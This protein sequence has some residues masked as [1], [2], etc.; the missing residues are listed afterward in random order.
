MIDSG[1]VSCL[2]EELNNALA[3]GFVEKVQQPAKDVILMTVRARGHNQKLLL[4]ASP[5]KARAHLTQMT[6]ESPAEAPMFCMLMRKYFS[7]AQMTAVSQPNDD[8][9]LEFSFQRTDELGREVSLRIVTEMIPGKTNIVLVG[10][11][12]LIIDCAY[13]RDYDADLYRRMY[14]GMIYR[15]PPH[16]ANFVPRGSADKFAS[17]EFDSL[18]SFLDAYY[19]AKEKE[20]VYRRRSRE[21]RTSLS[22]AEKR[23][24]KKLGSQR[25]ELQQTEARDEVRR[26]AELIT[27]NIW[28]IRRGDASL[29]CE[30]YYAEGSPQLSIE[31][32]PLLSPQANAAKLYK[33]YNRMKTAREYLTV[34]IDKAEAQLDYIAS[35]YDELDR[36]RSD[37]EIT[38][39]RN[40][41]IASGIIRERSGKAQKPQKNGKNAKGKREKPHA[42][43]KAT[44]PSGLEVLI[45]LNN[46]QNDVLTFTEANRNDLWFHV[47]GIHGSHVILRS[48]GCEA[49]E[50]DLLFAA[51]CAVENSQGR[52]STNIAVDYTLVRYVKKPS[53]AL[54]GK[55]IYTEQKTLIVQNA[56]ELLAQHASAREKKI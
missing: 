3:G 35:V 23:I 46:A 27:A 4:S 10:A 55:V 41:L 1:F 21:L 29:T 53:G 16:P 32:D 37:S 49:T 34:L 47:K 25:I 40:E 36:A 42:P 19:S 54:P 52:G 24:R 13:R 22:S 31:L 18:S 14:P 8:R 6:Y 39:I 7:G 9:I 51:A 15:L 5:G 17:D 20:E 30:N 48:A 56:A 26:N 2:R 43:A 50:D 11:D 38:D 44:A 28:R 45:G 12:G 33:D